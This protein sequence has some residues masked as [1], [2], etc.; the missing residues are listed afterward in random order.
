VS[1]SL[2]P[3]PLTPIVG[4]ERELQELGRLMASSRLITLTG[5]GGSGKTRLAIEAVSRFA[6]GDSPAWV[7]LAPLAD[8]GL[9]T[10]HVSRALE[11]HGEGVSGA[12]QALTHS[13]KTRSL[14]LVLDN[15]EHLVDACARLVEVL[16]KFCAPLKILA[17]SREPL[18]LPGEKIWLVPPL[19][20]P[21]TDPKLGLEE[22]AAT[23]AARL[24]VERAR[25]ASPTFR[26]TEKNAA[27]VAAI[28]RRLDGLPLALELAAA[29]TRVLSPEQIAERLDDTFRLLTTGGRTSLPRQKTLRGAFD[30]SHDLLGEEQRIL[31]RRLSVFVGGFSLDAVESLADRDRD[32]ADGALDA[33]AALV[34]R[35]LVQLEPESE[36]ARYRLLEIVRQ[37]SRE[38]LKAAGEEDAYLRRHA[39]YYLGLAE[40]WAPLLF[41][42]T[43][44][45]R[46]MAEVDREH[47]NLRAV[48]D[49]AMATPGELEAALRIGTALHWYWY[50]RGH[51]LEGWRR[52]ESAV[53]LAR[54]GPARNGQPCEPAVLARAMVCLGLFSVARG[55]PQHE[56]S[57]MAEAVAL[58]RRH[59]EPSELAYALTVQA[60][61][62]SFA[63]AEAALRAAAEGLALLEN[64]PDDLLKAFACH[65]HGVASLGHGDLAQAR[66]SCVRTVV[67]GHTLGHAAAIAHATY[68]LALIDSQLGDAAGARR[69]L[70]ESLRLHQQMDTRWGLSQALRLAGQIAARAGEPER[71]LKVL[72][73]AER[74]REELGNHLPPPEQAALDQALAGLRSQLGKEKVL[75][76][77]IEGARLDLGPLIGLALAAP[78]E[79][80]AL[81]PPPPPVAAAPPA[82]SPEPPALLS[83][84]LLPP[85]APDPPSPPAGEAPAE[86]APSFP[87]GALRVAALG[88]L[89]VEI[90]GVQALDALGSARTRELLVFLLLQPNGASK[91]EVGLALWPEASASQ[92]RNSFH[93]TLHR[94]RG[95]LGHPEAIEVNGGRYAVDPAFVG[96]FDV[97]LFESG[98][99]AALAAVKKGKGSP[100]E[101]LAA[102]ELYRGELLQGEPAGEWHLERRDRLQLLYLELLNATGQQLCDA[103]RFA[104][105]SEIYRRF[106]VADDLAE[107]AYRRLMVSLEASG[108]APEGLRVYRKLS[109]VLQK[110]LDVEPEPASREIFER[111]QRS[112]RSR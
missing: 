4:R 67:I 10:D 1:P 41:A 38:R 24:F 47:D 28:C 39:A 84:A 2:L 75:A 46:L 62:E 76:L 22:L 19:S 57:R 59:G 60:A 81:D 91:E 63:D 89:Q 105:A 86:P 43:G 108:Q 44:D 17:T 98:A 106:I 9:L 77:M 64:R 11:V 5:A 110:E 72:G 25:E 58:L 32:L 90:A 3:T 49:W 50:F 61:V 100:A 35:S 107:D 94:L 52:I 97:P 96:F 69:W 73:G 78:G 82:K 74:M 109:Q 70:A 29:R 88:S 102:V 56:R 15:C 51:L 92:I 6:A 85:A 112:S 8:G 34:D 99:K 55:E 79:P 13:L 65:W 54:K 30:W 31:L 66:A 20:L 71:G 103:G 53:G 26:L 23:D 16:L 48:A 93:V 101:L 42:G 21:G 12:T 33:L 36:P 18:G 45:E 111:L 95:V 7:D 40:G 14:L 80:P 83:P 87:P 68:F 104:E 37:Y 27:A